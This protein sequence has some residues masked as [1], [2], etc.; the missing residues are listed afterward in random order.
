MEGAR[1]KDGGRRA[2]IVERD[3]LQGDKKTTR[4]VPEAQLPDVEHWDHREMA[5]I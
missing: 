2:R 3:I 4:R 1:C 5:I